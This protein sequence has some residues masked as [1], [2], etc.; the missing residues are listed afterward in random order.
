[1]A[2]K[3]A[4]KTSRKK[5]ELDQLKAIKSEL[6]EIKAE[7]DESKAEMDE[8]KEEVEVEGANEIK[9]FAQ[10]EQKLD[11][12]KVA[13]RIEDKITKG[14][15][16]R[17]LVGS[18]VGMISV[19]WESTL[20]DVAA[21][22]TY[23]SALFIVVVS[24]LGAAFVLNFSQFKKITDIDVLKKI[25]PKRAVFF[26]M[27]SLTVVFCFMLLFGINVIGVTAVSIMINR[28]LLVALPAV[29]LACAADII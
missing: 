19:V 16:A 28:T 5:S 10:F 23:W 12:L 8:L 25:I 24:L 26:Y 6:D 27:L 21:G 15:I 29:L 2:K 20:W 1:M 9:E 22:M 3:R 17:G 11:K 13:R 4:K 7:V 14:D 18:M